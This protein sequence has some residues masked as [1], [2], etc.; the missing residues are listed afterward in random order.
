MNI[1]KHGEII[2]DVAGGRKVK[3]LFLCGVIT[4][5]K[6]MSFAEPERGLETWGKFSKHR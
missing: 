1:E 5:N 4:G 6:W 2:N 3:W